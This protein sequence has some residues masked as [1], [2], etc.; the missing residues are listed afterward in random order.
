[1]QAINDN[2]V[3]DA[4][5]WAAWVGPEEL[6]L[7]SPQPPTG[8]TVWHLLA[9]RMLTPSVSRTRLLEISAEKVGD[10]YRA[11]CSWHGLF[12]LRQWLRSLVACAP[13]PDIR[14]CVPTL[15]ALPTTLAF[16][17]VPDAPS[18]AMPVSDPSFSVPVLPI[19]SGDGSSVAFSLR[20]QDEEGGGELGT[21]SV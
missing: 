5:W 19:V 18:R 9:A 4:I 20:P 10:P 21:F 14:P 13:P 12:H 1:M 7:A 8:S 2:R 3:D 16:C 17:V 11:S 6:H 15:A